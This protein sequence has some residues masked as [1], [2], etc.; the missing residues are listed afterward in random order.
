ML[1]SS[2][3][4]TELIAIIKDSVCTEATVIWMDVIFPH[5]KDRS[6]TIIFRHGL[7]KNISEAGHG[8]SVGY[9]LIRLRELRNPGVK[10]SRFFLFS[11]KPRLRISKKKKQRGHKT[12]NKRC[13]SGAQQ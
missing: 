4:T 8:K 12:N 3:E 9:L 11:P 6:A 10:L 13:L 7:Q 2:T 1:K 5:W